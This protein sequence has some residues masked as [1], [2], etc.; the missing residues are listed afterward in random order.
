MNHRRQKWSI[1]YN[2]RKGSMK[3]ARDIVDAA[4]MEVV[5]ATCS[6]DDDTLDILGLDSLDR[7]EMVMMIE[8][9]GVAI[10]DEAVEKV[11]TY[12]ELVKLVEGL[13]HAKTS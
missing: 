5:G 11:K 13:L 7:V 6:R 3:N 1:I 12:G 4:L 9:S 8:E 10:T 2:K